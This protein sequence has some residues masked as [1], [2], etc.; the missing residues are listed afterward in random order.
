MASSISFPP[1]NILKEYLMSR[2]EVSKD[3]Q[4]IELAIKTFGGQQKIKSEMQNDVMSMLMS[5]KLNPQARIM[6]TF[7]LTRALEEWPKSPLSKL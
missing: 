3:T 1:D 4:V 6:M 5:S 7:K 2:P